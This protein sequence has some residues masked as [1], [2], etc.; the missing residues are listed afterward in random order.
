MALVSWLLPLVSMA[1]FA[2]GA[3]ADPLEI[4]AARDSVTQKIARSGLATVTGTVRDGETSCPLPYAAVLLPD[5]N[6]ATTAD[7]TGR[8]ILPRV[9]AG[10]HILTIRFIGHASRTL[11]LF[12][13]SGGE[14]EVGVTLLPDPIYLPPVKVGTSVP[15]RGASVGSPQPLLDRGSSIEAVKNHPLLAEPDVLQALAGGEIVEAA[16]TPN[17]VHVRG[18]A[19]DQIGYLLDGIPVFSPYHSS[20]LFSAWNPD[21][22]S[23]LD[24][25]S[26]A[27]PAAYPH[28]LSGAASAVT[29]APGAFLCAQGSVSTTHSR[30]TV[31]GP[32]GVADARYLLSFRSGYPGVFAPRTERSY[33]RGDTGDWMAKLEMPM[34][35]GR[36]RVLAYGSDN[37]ISAAARMEVDGVPTPPTRR[38]AFEWSSQSVGGEWSRSMALAT[39]RVLGW[40]ALGDANA[41]WSARRSPLDMTAASRDAGFLVSADRVRAGGSTSIGIRLERIGTSY[42]IE[43]DSTMTRWE[44]RARLTLASPFAQIARTLGGGAELQM[45]T[46]A[47]VA[48][49]R[50]HWEPRAQVQWRMSPKLAFCGAYAHLQQFAQSLRNPESIVGNIFPVD[51]YAVAGTPG[52]P[53]AASDQCAI[54]TEYR[55]RAGVRI[56]AQAYDRVSHQ[57]L[58][59][60][61]ADGEP[62]STGAFSVGSGISR[63]LS[64]DAGVSTTRVGLT[65]SYGFQHVRLD[66]AA[67]SYVP[68]QG[69][70]HSFTGGV[71][72]FPNPAWSV[73]F[74]VTGALGRRATALDDGL[75]W[76]APNL[77][78]RGSEFGG[79][80]HAAAAL[81]GTALPAYLRG[82]VGL[83]R[84]W[85]FGAAGH[86]AT[87]AAFGTVTNVFGRKNI[88]T[89]GID[90]ATGKPSPIEMRP[91]APLVAGLD[92][93]F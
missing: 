93:R 38:N 3:A 20:G 15:V 63:G 4:D 13:P 87:L 65:A 39:V 59:V 30:F 28:F 14:L 86:H 54:A 25:S 47:T 37:D 41:H 45:G 18:A 85:R 6:R 80:P 19:S 22:L 58:L 43:P 51:L 84:I 69:I 82:D 53:V 89:Y 40:N 24:L 76:E 79:S 61:P 36:G 73:R 90:P 50:L 67:S 48:R 44:S 42:R 10:P 62:F 71:M 32:L 27:P 77:L 55:P 31:D 8:Y 29:R 1:G 2:A 35:G 64:V 91:L 75:E 7:S 72:L 46:A 57:L 23:R 5:Q 16:E 68:E 34:L 60:A 26:M 33:L 49:G 81:G 74:G 78:D 83:R 17:G 56:L 21:A 70:E 52:V 11:Y 88:L 9:A 12:V 66:H 92:W